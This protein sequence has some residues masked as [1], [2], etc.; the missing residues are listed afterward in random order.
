MERLEEKYRDYLNSNFDSLMFN[1]AKYTINT[2]KN[3]QNK[4]IISFFINN[5]PDSLKNQ[6]LLDLEK[7]KYYNKQIEESTRY[8]MVA[9]MQ[10]DQI[11]SDALDN[12]MKINSRIMEEVDELKQFTNSDNFQDNFSKFVELGKVQRKFSNSANYN[13]IEYKYLIDVGGNVTISA[14]YNGKEIFYITYTIADL[15]AESLDMLDEQTILELR[16]S[17]N[18][19]ICDVSKLSYLSENSCYI[20]KRL[21][22][23]YSLIKWQDG[24]YNKTLKIISKNQLSDI[25]AKKCG[26]MT[27]NDLIE[28]VKIKK[29]SLS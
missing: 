14:F 5:I 6:L 22:F 4:N 29:R 28:S 11:F 7:S 17:L 20:I 19:D 1:L 18:N 9:A 25:L 27:E 8:I 15:Y 16:Y 12:K 10:A 3:S 2:E 24:R 13:N 23:C 21:P 26:E